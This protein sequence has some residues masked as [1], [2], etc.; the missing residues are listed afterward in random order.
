MSAKT[1]LLRHKRTKI[2]LLSET[3]V[4]TTN[5]ETAARVFERAG[6]RRVSYVEWRSK[7]RAIRLK[8]NAATY[9]ELIKNRT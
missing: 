6:F 1:K 8:D 3:G 4:A 7:R 2:Y 9:A 5:N